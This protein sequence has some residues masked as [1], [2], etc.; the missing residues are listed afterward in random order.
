MSYFNAANLGVTG[1][2]GVYQPEV[3]ED[4]EKQPN[5]EVKHEESAK[6][7]ISGSDVLSYMANA[8]QQQMMIQKAEPKTV[9]VAQYVD[10]ASS[11]RIEDAI[12]EFEAKY[13]DALDFTMSE[14][15]DLSKEAA[16]S[17]ALSGLNTLM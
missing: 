12:K 2:K 11:A 5:Q 9:N 8:A 10:D 1:S 16:E 14:F 3:K 7:Q 13:K 6:K 17:I 4:V 15:A